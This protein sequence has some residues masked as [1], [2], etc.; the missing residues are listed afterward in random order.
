MAHSQILLTSSEGTEFIIDRDIADKSMLLKCML[1][2]IGE[3]G[4]GASLLFA[5]LT[6]YNME[7]FRRN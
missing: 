2:D 7:N 5:F 4:Q 6:H 1:E 3:I